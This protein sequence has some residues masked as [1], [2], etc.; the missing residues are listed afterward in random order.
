MTRYEEYDYGLP[1][2]GR[3]PISDQLP[4]QGDSKPAFSA[5]FVDAED[6]IFSILMPEYVDDLNMECG[7]R[8]RLHN[9]FTREKVIKDLSEKCLKCSVQDACPW[10]R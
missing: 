10:V 2:K 6:D 3:V 9:H 7:G 4:I 8:E 5:L 1:Q